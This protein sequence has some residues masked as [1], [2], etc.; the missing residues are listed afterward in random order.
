MRDEAM[1]EHYR[2]VAAGEFG[3]LPEVECPSCGG[4]GWYVGHEDECWET[5]DCNC[6]GV[7]LQCEQCQGSGS[8]TR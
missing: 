3:G 7:Q 8:V 5:G 4:D 6:S 1:D 2:R